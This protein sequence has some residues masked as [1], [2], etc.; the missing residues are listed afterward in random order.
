MSPAGE[1]VMKQPT[2]LQSAGG[3]GDVEKKEGGAPSSLSE[4]E[5]VAETE[6]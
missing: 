4:P 1:A 3:E 2:S 5:K 6:Q